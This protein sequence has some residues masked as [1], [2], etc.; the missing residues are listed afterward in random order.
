MNFKDNIKKPYSEEVISALK[1]WQPK[2]FFKYYMKKWK[3]FSCIICGSSRSGKSNMLRYIIDDKGCGVG[4]EFDLIIVFSR[5]ICNGFYQ[6]FIN[7]KLMF[8]SYNPE[9]IKEMKLVYEKNKEK[10]K[11]IKTLFIF[12]DIVDNKSKY[13]DEI[14]NLFYNGRH[15][16][17]SVFFLSQKM[18]LCNVGW[19]SNAVC[20]IS[21]F[22]GARAEKEYL[23]E[24]IISDAIDKDHKTYRSKSE[25]IRTAYILQST[26]CQN[27]Q[28]LIVLPYEKDNLFKFKAPYIK[29]KNKKFEQKSIFE[30]F[31]NN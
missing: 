15:F 22:S 12:D 27:Y 1:E 21:L 8:S 30:K 13:Q 6:S 5:T 23:A 9:I 4:K 2:E 7:S 24:K 17:F 26:I 28:A 10:G 16:Y 11:K 19:L 20:I 18:S 25:M 3:G 31:I 14:T 29:S